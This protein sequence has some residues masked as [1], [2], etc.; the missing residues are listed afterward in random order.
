MGMAE[1]EIGAWS[2]RTAIRHADSPTRP[3]E[4]M[5][6]APAGMKVGA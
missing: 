2:V 6:R 4:L 3:S 5:S 1:G